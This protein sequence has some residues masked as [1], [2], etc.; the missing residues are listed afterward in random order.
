MD[1]EKLR[2]FSVVAKEEHMTRS[3]AKLYITQPALSNIISN[4]EEELQVKLF[5]RI[6]RQIILNDYGREFAESVD[7]ILAEYDYAV[8]RVQSKKHSSNQFLTVAVTGLYFAQEHIANFMDEYPG[9]RVKTVHIRASEIEDVMNKGT[10]QYLLS[11]LPYQS[12]ITQLR[13][14]F[15]EPLVLA[16]SEKHPLASMKRVS[17]QQLREEPFALMPKDTAFR[18][19]CDDIFEKAQFQPDVILEAYNDQMLDAVRKGKAITLVSNMMIRQPIFYGLVPLSIEEDYC[20]RTIYLIHR[21]DLK[22]GNK[23]RVFSDY[24]VTHS[25]T[26]LANLD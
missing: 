3:A 7:K 24:L 26:P 13:P 8:Q 15:S 16:V 1:I 17:L 2:C 11:S 23:E 25:A 22:I 14:L 20:S 19:V 6:G 12:P 4:I 21:N 5:T 10:V 9:L 18:N